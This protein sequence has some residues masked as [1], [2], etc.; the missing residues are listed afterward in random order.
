M[1]LNEYLTDINKAITDCT[2]TGL[3]ISS[4]VITDIRTEKIGFVKG[5]LVFLDG[6]T[7]FFKEYLDLR[8]R[9]DKKT[10]SFHYQDVQR[11]HNATMHNN[12]TGTSTAQ[13]TRDQKV[14]GCKDV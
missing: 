11:A 4:E 2:E 1:L 12:H 7:L 14:S 8:F 13:C 6:S 9:L 10:Y 3:I 5:A